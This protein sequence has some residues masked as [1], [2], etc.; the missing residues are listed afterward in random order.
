M[1]NAVVANLEAAVV[2][3]D[4][5][6]LLD[7][8]RRRG[9]EIAFDLGMKR[10]L[11]ALDGEQVVGPGIEGRLGD[12]DLAAHGIG[13]DQGTLEIEPL[14]QSRYR[15]DLVGFFK[16][17]L[18]AKHQPAVGRE[19]GH[20]VERAPR[21][22]QL[23]TIAMVESRIERGDKIESERRSYISSRALSAAAF[24]AAARGHW[25]IKN[26]RTGFST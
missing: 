3:V 24:A 11:V 16:Y 15:G 20:Q 8:G 10:R 21:F 12:G 17:R 2:L 19:G 23:T 13:R 5:L 14:D 26:K 1:G 6:D 4:G 18:L 22:P 9:C 7:F 25:A